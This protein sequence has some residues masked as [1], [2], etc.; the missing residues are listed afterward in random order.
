MRF[1]QFWIL[2]SDQGLESDVQ[3]RQYTIEDRTD[4]WLQ[5]MGPEGEEGLDLSQDAR[6]LVSRLDSGT[7]LTHPFPEGRG[8]YVYL[9]EGEGAFDD[10]K[11][12]AGD[13][14]KVFGPHELT[15]SAVEPMEVI[16]ADVV[17]DYEPVG[18]W[19]GQD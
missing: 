18:V 9:M 13:A 14:A 12:T 7:V 19:A 1:I 16:V 3:Q 8:G 2:P 15:V 5:I 4:R 6:V 11:V 17:L 10:D